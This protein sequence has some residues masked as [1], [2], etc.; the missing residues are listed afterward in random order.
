M[1]DI[2]KTKAELIKELQALRERNAELEAIDIQRKRVEEA[3]SK[4]GEFLNALLENLADGIA[5]CDAN[6]ILT[7]L[8]RASRE[9]HGEGLSEEPLTAEK[10]ADYYNLYLPD[11]KTRMRVTDIP[12]F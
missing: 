9:F 10:W 7:L 11:G 8:N 3:F 5:A 12:L 6:G 4:Q 1:T 2:S